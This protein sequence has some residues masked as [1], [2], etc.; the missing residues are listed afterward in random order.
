MHVYSSYL[1]TIQK[2]VSPKESTI[3]CYS[4]IIIKPKMSFPSVG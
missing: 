2:T 3:F 1:N 4:A